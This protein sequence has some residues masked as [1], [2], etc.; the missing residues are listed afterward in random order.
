MYLSDFDKTRKTADVK[1]NSLFYSTIGN[2][3]FFV[4]KLFCLFFLS[5]F[6]FVISKVVSPSMT[7][8]CQTHDFLVLSTGVYGCSPRKVLLNIASKYQTLENLIL[9]KKNNHSI[10][11]EKR[12]KNLFNYKFLKK[13]IFSFQKPQRGDIVAFKAPFS[14]QSV[15]TKRITG[16]P[17]DKI[18][19]SN[20]VLIINGKPVKLEYQ[21]LFEWVENEKK[22]SAHKYVETLPNGVSYEV[23]YQDE[24]GR[25]NYLNNTEEFVVPE[26]HYFMNG[27][28]RNNSMDS[29]NFLGFIPEENILAKG[30]FILFSNGNITTLNPI[31]IFEGWKSDRF[32]AWLR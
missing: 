14:D 12:L 16:I 24:L 17:G 4:I 13:P 30:I 26:G 21:G 23:I 5:N 11:E 20:G 3:L 1:Y 32:F 31:K 10:K 29:R 9:F 28:N 25:F 8:S 6:F 22:H 7:P 15:Y 18:K 19:F 27:D 2:I